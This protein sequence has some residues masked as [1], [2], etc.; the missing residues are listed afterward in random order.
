MTRPTETSA[1]RGSVLAAAG[2]MIGLS[3]VLFWLPIAGPAIAGFVGGRKAGSV[4]KAIVAAFAPAVAL[5][6]LVAVVLIAFELP[7]VGAVA[8]VGLLLF[9]LAEDVPLFIGA[10]VGAGLAEGT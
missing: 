1:G 6:A 10:M 8:G 7:L 2:W 9:I 3:V 4:R 5:G